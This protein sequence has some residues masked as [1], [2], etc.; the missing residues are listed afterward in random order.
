[1]DLFDRQSMRLDMIQ[2]LQR[3]EQSFYDALR[4][5]LNAGVRANSWP[6]ASVEVQYQVD[7]M[8]QNVLQEAQA[9]VIDW[10][11]G[12]SS[13]IEYVAKSRGITLEEAKQIV[14]QNAEEY[15]LMEQAGMV[16]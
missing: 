15:R 11:N 13:P 10:K 8:P 7:E 12:I 16:E 5:V 9:R 2:S 1:M 14:E 6:A 3:G 4:L